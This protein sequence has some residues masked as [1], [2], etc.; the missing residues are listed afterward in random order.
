MTEAFVYDAIRTPRGRG[1]ATGSLYEVKPVS[2]VTGLLQALQQRNPGLDPAAIDDVILG[3]VTP[4]GDPEMPIVTVL[5][6]RA[7]EEE[8]TEA[9]EGEEGAEGAEA[10]EGAEGGSAAASDTS[11]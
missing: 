5:V 2:L 4:V 3:C 1:K 6:M 7:A 11:E 8:T 10:A 9:A